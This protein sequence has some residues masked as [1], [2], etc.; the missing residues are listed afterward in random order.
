[1][2]CR[3]PRARLE[4]P[5]GGR[6]AGLA[7]V[8]PGGLVQRMTERLERRLPEHPGDLLVPSAQLLGLFGARP[9]GQHPDHG[10]FQR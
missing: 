10:A 3:G 4:C 5:L 6:D 7:R 9:L 1:M 8:D 2:G